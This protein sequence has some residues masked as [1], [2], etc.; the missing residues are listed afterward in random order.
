TVLN[1]LHGL[2][3]FEVVYV[4]TNGGPGYATDVLYTAIFKE[5]SMGRYGVGTALSSILFL[6][7]T[8]VGYFVVRLMAREE[9]RD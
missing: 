7:M 5:F 4:L 9:A 1:L 2:K 3:V 6:F 8:I